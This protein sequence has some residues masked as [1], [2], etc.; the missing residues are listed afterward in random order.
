MV[1]GWESSQERFY[2]PDTGPYQYSHF[3]CT[4]SLS[5]RHFFGLVLTHLHRF[6]NNLDDFRNKKLQVFYVCGSDLLPGTVSHRVVCI[7]RKG[8][9]D[10]WRQLFGKFIDRGAI[11][12]A[13]KEVREM[14]STV[15][16]KALLEMNHTLLDELLH[17]AVKEYLLANKLY[18]T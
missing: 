17:P 4:L 6:I 1:D 3:Y 9:D 12:V 11:L 2:D 16:R 8:D 10:S 15:I 13:D 7:P 18:G 14:S 5:H